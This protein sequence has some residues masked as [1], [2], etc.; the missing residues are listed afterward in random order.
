VSVVAKTTLREIDG[1]IADVRT[2]LDVTTGRLVE[3][4]A[5]VTRQLLESSTTLR[6]VT[7]GTW[8][9]ASARHAAL[10]QGQIALDRALAKVVDVRG[11]RRFVTQSALHELDDLLGGLGV[12]LPL[13][14]AGAPVRLTQGAEPVEL[15]TVDA[16]LDRMS[17]D[18]EFVAAAVLSVA[19]VWGPM[20][21]KLYVLHETLSRVEAGEPGG[22][23]TSPNELR[24][25]RQA[26]DAAIGTARDDPLGLPHRA[27]TDLE[28]RVDRLVSSHEEALGARVARTHEL[29]EASQQIEAALDALSGCRDELWR[30]AEKVTVP[31]GVEA[32]MALLALQLARLRAACARSEQSAAGDPGALSRQA[33]VVGG[34]VSA[35][36]AA[37]SGR[38]AQRDQL[39]G[40]LEAYRAKADS[41]GLAEDVELEALFA[42]ARD[43]LF[44]APCDIEQAQQA[45]Q[46]CIDAA[47]RSG[48]PA[49]G[50][51]S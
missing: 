25:T 3:L 6:G 36:T 27:V 32:E 28:A 34:R 23:V 44:V 39:R 7:R 17:A 42:S 33:H 47:R 1:R 5:D 31:D 10:W 41:L 24:A 8:A 51:G 26:L 35:L 46:A 9:D 49:A 40:L 29:R 16:A 30:V 14:D 21:E 20:S 38:L 15:V 37:V 2:V 48:R 11:E 12:E 45:V 4:D 43:L 19:E 13:P 22:L 18:Y 50:A